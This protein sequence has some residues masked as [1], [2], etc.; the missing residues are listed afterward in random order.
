MTRS[1]PRARAARTARLPD[2]PVAPSTSTVP[3]GPTSLRRAISGIQPD[4]PGFMPAA[5][6]SG[7]APAPTGPELC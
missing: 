4:M 3:S 7:S 1:A 6:A 5:T 2:M